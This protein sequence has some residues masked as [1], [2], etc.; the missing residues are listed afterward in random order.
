MISGMKLGFSNNFFCALYMSSV[1][2]SWYMRGLGSKSVNSTGIFSR[3]RKSASIVE[4]WR[5][6]RNFVFI[7]ASN[8]KSL[9]TAAVPNGRQSKYFIMGAKCGYFGTP[10]ASFV[11]NTTFQNSRAVFGISCFLLLQYFVVENSS[12]FISWNSLTANSWLDTLA[13]FGKILNTCIM[14]EVSFIAF[15]G[16]K[17]PVNGC[18]LIWV[19]KIEVFVFKMF[20]KCPYSDQS[21]D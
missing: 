19:F 18:N 13:M 3:R 12:N 9:S 2:N 11:L 16:S 17:K 10:E 1:L 20:T 6:F 8:E 5:R 7:K 4:T 15:P 21:Q 14:L